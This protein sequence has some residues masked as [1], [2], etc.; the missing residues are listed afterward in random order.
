[1]WRCWRIMEAIERGDWPAQISASKLITSVPFPFEWGAQRTLLGMA[2][3][4]RALH[5]HALLSQAGGW[6][7][8]DIARC[9]IQC[10]PMP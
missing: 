4:I 8:S 1:M 10:V 6:S 3:R 2:Q 7:E 5:L 9:S